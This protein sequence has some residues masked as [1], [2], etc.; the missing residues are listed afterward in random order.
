M[1]PPSAGGGGVL[2][3]GDGVVLGEWVG[4][5]FGLSGAFVVV[6]LVGPSVAPVVGPFVGPSVGPS[7]GPLVGPSVG[8]VL[9][10]SVG[11]WPGVDGVSLGDGVPADGV[12]DGVLLG[13]LADGRATTGLVDAVTY[14][15]SSRVTYGTDASASLDC[16]WWSRIQEIGVI[17]RI[18]VPIATVIRFRRDSGRA[19]AGLLRR[20]RP[21][22]DR[23]DI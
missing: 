11:F 1:L 6:L 15:S 10:P 17:T 5:A 2:V 21:A 8:V 14:V 7:V 3:L 12:P 13:V 23:C 4:V 16:G 9:G 18:T 20:R 19:V 22:A